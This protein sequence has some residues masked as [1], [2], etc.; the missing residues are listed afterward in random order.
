MTMCI[1]IQNGPVN[2]ATSLKAGASPRKPQGVYSPA[3]QTRGTKT[4]NP[5]LNSERRFPAK[6]E[7]VPPTYTTSEVLAV[8]GVSFRKLDYWCR[9]G[10]IPG[11][12]EPIGSGH[13]RCWTGSDLDRI[14]LLM[15]ASDI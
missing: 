14:R 8:L 1:S 5:T 12:F 11:H 10:Y 6:E 7:P 15:M 4:M 13:R 3:T 2:T 9:R